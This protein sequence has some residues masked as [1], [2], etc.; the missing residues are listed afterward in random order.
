VVGGRLQHFWAASRVEAVSVFAHDRG[1][2]SRRDA[3]CYHAAMLAP[4]KVNEIV[5]KAASAVL[6]RQAG[7]Q[8]VVSEPAVDSDGDEVLH[9]TIVLKRGSADKISGDKALDTLVGIDRALREASEDR[10]PIIDFVTEEE[11]ESVGD[12]ES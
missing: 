1:S 11:L 12:T 7:V 5:K 2:L 3:A 9:I 8:R 10:F 4:A 6:K